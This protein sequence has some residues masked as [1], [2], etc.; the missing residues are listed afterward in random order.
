MTLY[1]DAETPPLPVFD[2]VTSPTGDQYVPHC[3]WRDLYDAIC[4]AQKFIYI[5]GNAITT[6]GL[7]NRTF[8]A[9]LLDLNYEIVRDGPTDQS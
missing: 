8:F 4:Q 6:T 5:T 3:A 1:Q 2:G 7:I 9:Y